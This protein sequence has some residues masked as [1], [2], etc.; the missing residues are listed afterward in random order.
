MFESRCGVLCAS[1]ARKEEVHC[2]G[3][4]EM[5]V[6]FWGGICAVKSCCEAKQL[7]HCGQCTQFPCE[8][9]CNMGKDQGFDP[10]PK[11]QHCRQWAEEEKA[12][13]I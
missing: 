3:C 7:N 10:L 6:P 11:L 4:P 9:L 8:M 1:C 13:N 5:P 12:Q 2:K